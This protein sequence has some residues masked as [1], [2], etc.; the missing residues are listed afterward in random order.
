MKTPTPRIGRGGRGLKTGAGI[1]ER[2]SLG[3]PIRPIIHCNL[4]I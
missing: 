2:P 3:R 1:F 4:V